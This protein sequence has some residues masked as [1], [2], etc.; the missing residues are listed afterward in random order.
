MKEMPISPG[1]EWNVFWGGAGWEGK[2][3][4]VLLDRVWKY[5]EECFSGTFLKRPSMTIMV[6]ST[7]T[8][9]LKV[10]HACTLSKVTLSW[11]LQH[12]DQGTSASQG[13]FHTQPDLV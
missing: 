13:F 1:H 7:G 11:G 12:Y 2:A 5:S 4:F 6:S 8:P 10:I 9:S 3:S